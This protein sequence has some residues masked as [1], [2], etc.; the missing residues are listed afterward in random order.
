MSYIYALSPYPD[1]VSETMY[2]FQ[3]FINHLQKFEEQNMYILYD[4]SW[5]SQSDRNKNT[6][7]FELVQKT[8]S[9]PN[10]RVK[11]YFDIRETTTTKGTR[12][13][14]KIQCFTILMT[15]VSK[16]LNV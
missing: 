15:K 4:T 9:L 14:N 10:T 3:K 1:I 6:T 7:L 16:P 12:S 13:G 2:D 5:K 8:F 11:H